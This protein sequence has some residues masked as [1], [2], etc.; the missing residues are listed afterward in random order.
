MSICESLVWQRSMM[1]R[2]SNCLP[3]S[4]AEAVHLRILWIL[5]T[6]MQNALSPAMLSKDQ[7]KASRLNLY[8]SFRLKSSIEEQQKPVAMILQIGR[9][10]GAVLPGVL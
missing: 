9:R 10:V 8:D 7:W 3:A 5:Q 6:S 4:S 1:W 2:I